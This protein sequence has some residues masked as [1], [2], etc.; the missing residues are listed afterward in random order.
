MEKISNK[1]E[2]T[3]HT[4]LHAEIWV[5]VV[6]KQ[7]RNQRWRVTEAKMTFQQ[8][9]HNNQLV[10]T[11]N[12]MVCLYCHL[13]DPTPIQSGLSLVLRSIH[14]VTR[15]LLQVFFGTYRFSKV[16]N[17]MTI[18]L[19]ISITSQVTSLVM[20]S[21]YH[22]ESIRRHFAFIVNIRCIRNNFLYF[23]ICYLLFV[24]LQ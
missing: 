15:N 14:V 6:P 8:N 4:G 1:S 23:L 24:F 2:S 9:Y 18:M 21:L 13:N 3:N 20:L 16:V 22:L 11:P 7:K 5:R 17:N 12:E 10:V 19:S